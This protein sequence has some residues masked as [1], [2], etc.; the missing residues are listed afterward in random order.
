MGFEPRLLV[1]DDDALIRDELEDLF[2][3]QPYEV[4]SV[5]SVGEAIEHLSQ[6]ECALALVDVRIGG[7]DGIELTQQIR[8]R[9]PEIDVIMITGHGSIENAVDAMKCGAVDYIT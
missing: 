3:R 8:S 5:A 9:W 6:H 4:S 7:K 2:A 1:V